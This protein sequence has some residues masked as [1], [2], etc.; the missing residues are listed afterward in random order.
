MCK[1]T[2]ITNDCKLIAHDMICYP[3]LFPICFYF[4]F[5]IPKVNALLPQK[6]MHFGLSF[7]KSRCTFGLASQKID[8][9]LTFISQTSM[10]FWF[11]FPKIDALLTFI[12]QKSMH[13]WSCFPKNRCTF[14]FHLP[15]VDA[16]LVLFPKK[17]MHF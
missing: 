2:N 7:P 1:K 4:E 12:S 5:H 14:D 13:F 3:A 15:K 17:S 8:A 16:L 6:S 11:C 9:L 10:H